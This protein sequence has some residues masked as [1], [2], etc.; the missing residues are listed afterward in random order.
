MAEGDVLGQAVFGEDNDSYMY[1]DAPGVKRCPGCGYHLDPTFV[2]PGFR[3]VR[4]GF[5]LSYTY[6]GCCIASERVKTFC[7]RQGYPGMTFLP[8]PSTP[9]FFRLIVDRVVEF[10]AVRRETRF[11]SNCP[12][13][14]RP[15]SVAGLTP[16]FLREGT[17]LNEGFYRTDLEFGTG[18]ERSPCLL[19]APSTFMRV[20]RERWRGAYFKEIRA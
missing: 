14:G 16:V 10:D 7:E 12:V 9:G 3:L 1:H 13:C 11:G 4:R 5:D 8:L 20:A 18:D 15:E 17:V 6:D 2:D 19:V